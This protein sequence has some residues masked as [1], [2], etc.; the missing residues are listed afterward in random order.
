MPRKLYGSVNG[1]TKQIRKLYGSVNGVTKEIVKLYGSAGGVTK[2]IFP[3]TTTAIAQLGRGDDINIKL[4]KLAGDNPDNTSSENH[5]IKA[6]RRANALPP[7]FVPSADNN[8]AHSTS[9]S[10]IYAWFDDTGGNGII[11]VFFDGDIKCHNL[12]C[13]C[14]AMHSLTDISFLS[15]IDTSGVSDTYSM[16]EDCESLSDLTPLSNW[17]TSG[18]KDLSYMFSRC[19]ALTDLSPLSNWDMSHATTMDAIFN[20]SN[21][22]DATVLNGWDVS[23]VTS[24]TNAFTCPADKRPTWYTP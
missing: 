24:M 11:Y 21:N 9:A 20:A 15:T 16:F 19:I 2:L 10:P 14:E 5:N 13:L 1:Q 18:F 23:N 12:V 4:K 3:D 6:L 22:I 7:G 8:I 17:D